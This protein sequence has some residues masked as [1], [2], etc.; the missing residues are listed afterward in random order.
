MASEAPSVDVPVDAVDLPSDLS[1]QAFLEREERLNPVPSLEQA[2]RVANARS[3]R[4]VQDKKERTHRL[5]L[6]LGVE[7]PD[8][9]PEELPEHLFRPRAVS[10]R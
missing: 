9:A 10:R 3:G 1:P 4:V 7:E 8:R 6:G 5:L 2:V